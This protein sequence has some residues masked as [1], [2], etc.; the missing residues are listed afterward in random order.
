MNSDIFV[1]S[2]HA[3]SHRS[4]RNRGISHKSHGNGATTSI[5]QNNNGNHVYILVATDNGNHITIAVD[6]AGAMAKALYGMGAGT[7]VMA[8]QIFKDA[9]AKGLAYKELPMATL[10][11]VTG[12]R[13][14]CTRW[15]DS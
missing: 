9:I 1:V 4:H 6:I 14:P 5:I 11:R 3:S 7:S 10:H 8:K 2:L 13:F 15:S 12:Q